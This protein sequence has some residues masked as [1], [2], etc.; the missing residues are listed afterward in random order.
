MEVCLT[1]AYGGKEFVFHGTL[2]D[3]PTAKAIASALPIEARA[4]TWG[5]EMYFRIPVDHELEPG[6]G[7]LREVGDLAYRPPGNALCIF[8]GP[9]PAPV[10]AKPVGT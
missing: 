7:D 6:A 9:T 3:C 5:G 1:T 2:D 8:F 10:S 4:S